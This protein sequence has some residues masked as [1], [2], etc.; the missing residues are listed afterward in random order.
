MVWQ[1]AIAGKSAP[2]FERIPMLEIGRM[3]ERAC[4]R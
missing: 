4:S 3:W 2:T 1:T